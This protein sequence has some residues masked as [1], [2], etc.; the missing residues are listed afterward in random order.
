MLKMNDDIAEVI[1][2]NGSSL[3]ILKVAKG[4]GF[5]TLRDAGL[6]KVAQGITSLEEVNRVIKT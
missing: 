1:M 5:Q 6:S 4:Q 2:T 3:D